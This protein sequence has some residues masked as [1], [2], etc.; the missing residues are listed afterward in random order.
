[1]LFNDHIQ[2][3][4][5]LIQLQMG[6]IPIKHAKRSMY[7]M[8]PTFSLRPKCSEIYRRWSIQLPSGNQPR[9]LEN[10]PFSSI[11]FPIQNSIYRCYL[12]FIDIYRYL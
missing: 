1:M 3:Y 11:L 8:F 12:I 4:Y 10:P 5:S 2:T 6:Y 9:G 7:G